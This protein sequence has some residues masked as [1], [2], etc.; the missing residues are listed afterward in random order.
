LQRRPTCDLYHSGLDVFVPEGRYTIERTQAS[1][2]GEKR[3][4]VGIGSIGAKWLAARI[5][6]FRYEL[7][8]WRDGVI[9]ESMRPWEVRYG[10]ATI[11]HRPDDSSSSRRRCRSWS[12]AAT[13]SGFT[14]NDTLP[15]TTRGGGYYCQRCTELRLATGKALTSKYGFE[16][17]LLSLAKR[18]EDMS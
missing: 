13:S 7:R 5:Y 1:A 14:F 16:P 11:S 3:G 4:V 10:L 2:G 18:S 17:Q 15:G 6:M 8:R 9:P 12:R